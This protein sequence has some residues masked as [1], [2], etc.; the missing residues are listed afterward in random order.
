MNISELFAAW[1]E[2]SIFDREYLSEESIK[3]PQLHSKWMKFLAT[4]RMKHKAAAQAHK[5][6]YR[7]KHSYYSGTLDKETL[8]QH[9]W[10][11][12]ELRVIRGDLSMYLDSDP[13]LGELQTKSDVAQEKVKFIEG[14]IQQI[15]VRG[16]QIKNVIQWE[17]FKAGL[18][19]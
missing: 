17:M 4:E 5:V 8:D 9:G 10:E 19:G 12:F 6:L 15:N 14:V 2:D 11:P 3:I 1:E 16:F 18:N 13:D 7:D